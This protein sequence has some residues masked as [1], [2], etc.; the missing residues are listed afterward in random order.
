VTLSILNGIDGKAIDEICALRD[1]IYRNQWITF[2][3][4]YFS[5]QVGAAID[6]QGPRT[7]SNPPG[8]ATW[9]TFARW[10]SY[11]VGENLRTDQPSLA[12][13]TYVAHHQV[14]RHVHGQLV[15]MQ[16]DLSTRN[17][18]AM[19]RL[20]ALGNRL[21]FQ[22]IGHAAA[23]MLAWHGS[24]KN[25]ADWP[26]YRA[27]IIP[28]HASNLFADGELS[29]LRDGI[30][31]YV[32]ASLEADPAARADLV[33]RGNI[34]L[35]AYEQWRLSPILKVAMDPVAKHLVE[36]RVEADADGA[37]IPVA[38]LKRDGT[39]F[40]LRHRSPLRQWYAERYAEGF[41]RSVLAWEGPVPGPAVAPVFLA[42]PVPASAVPS[43]DPVQQP[44][45]KNL[46]RMFN[47]AAKNKLGY[48]TRSWV[49]YADRMNAV[50][51]LF[52]SQQQ[53][54]ALYNAVSTEELRIL[55]LELTDQHLDQLRD[56]GDDVMEAI[57][58]AFVG[59]QQLAPRD[60]VRKLVDEG[61]LSTPVTTTATAAATSPATVP[62]ALPAWH[63]NQLLGEG[64][65]FLAKYGLE[66]ASALFTASLPWSY[67]G[68]RGA[69]VLVRTAQLADTHTTR[70]VAETGQM[71]QD[72]MTRDPVATP[73]AP[74]TQASNA[75]RGVRMFH[76]AVRYM[77]EHDPEVTWD[78][79]LG[80]PINQE[81]LLGTVFV[82]TVVVLDALT[83]LGVS[84]TER[85]AEAYVHLWLVVGHLLGVDYGRW[86]GGAVRIDGAPL[87]LRELR[88]VGAS[89]FRRNATSSPAGVT[90]MS[91]LLEAM[92][93]QM[94]RP[95]RHYPTSAVRRLIGTEYADMLEVG[96]AGTGHV[97]Y[98]VARSLGRAISP[99]LD[100]KVAGAFITWTTGRVYR[101][102]ITQER[103]SRPPW[104]S[105]ERPSSP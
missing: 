26:G 67:T 90:L 66:I 104:Q 11:T 17:D 50:V 31:C 7:L 73:L 37:E 78:P 41:T 82:F 57:F 99:R 42:K 84:Y 5:R 75:V 23:T 79:S 15:R 32:A 46:V 43:P 59:N 24:T 98:S 102:W 44:T 95:L 3:Y 19:P 77:I 105:L 54:P 48:G 28:Q 60:L 36:F 13:D 38:V 45:T 29:S 18:A 35:A 68:G 47:R 25:P 14:L 74:G 65:D 10:S 1:D 70:R 21:V 97:I 20:L 101:Y 69:H 30:D 9:Y 93:E 34:L 80:V 6:G 76:E 12:F 88:I 100:G 72:L 85:E 64:Q 49:K 58:N 89:I 2:A 94:P 63:D 62:A 81:D 8:N 71:L 51:H 92:K 103:G 4:D 33:L 16:Q 61:L 56:V 52:R 55:D 96:H 22:E 27:E 40:S 83:H 91:S 39:L 86:R 87:T 53:N